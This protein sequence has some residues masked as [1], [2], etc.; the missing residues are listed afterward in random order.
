[1]CI[2]RFPGQETRLIARFIREP[3]AITCRLDFAGGREEELKG[4]TAEA[5][6]SCLCMSCACI[7]NI[8]DDYYSIYS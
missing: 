2:G 5:L 7:Y 1:M 4:L 8:V 3:H 6:F